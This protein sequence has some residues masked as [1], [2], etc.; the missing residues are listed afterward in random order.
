MNTE[1]KVIKKLYKLM[2]NA[3]NLFVEFGI[4]YYV[5][6]GTLLGAVRHKGIIPWDN[7]LD[8]EILTDSVKT[9]KSKNFKKELDKVKIKVRPHDEG[10]Y[11]MI[12]KTDDY[13]QIDIFVSKYNEKKG[14]VE[15]TKPARDIFP[16]CATWKVK[17]L[18]PLKKYKFGKIQVIGP[19]N[20]IPYLDN[21]YGKSWSK[22]GYITMNPENH[23]ELDEPIKVPVKRFIAARE[24]YIPRKK[25]LL[26]R[27]G[28]KIYSKEYVLQG[29]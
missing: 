3:H 2:F 17:D 11:K 26:P 4:S 18:F 14:V 5:N 21:C 8:L 6:G 22:I 9:L 13:I 24:F 1:P 19:Q 29:Q 15:L 23:D 28:N 27:K 7:D 12:D 16:K 20:P 25:Q 10:W